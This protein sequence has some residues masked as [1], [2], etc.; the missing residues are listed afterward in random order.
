MEL[1]DAIRTRRSIRKF[2][3]DPVPRDIIIKI[4]EAA[5]LAPSAGNKQCWEF[6]VLQRS[7]LDRMQKILV[8]SFQGVLDA[9]S[10]DDFREIVKDLPIPCDDSQDK[11]DGLKLF[12]KYLGNAP[13]AIIVTVPKAEDKWTMHNNIKDG[14]AATQNLLL[15][16]WNEGLGTCWMT[17][18]LF[19]R[20]NEIF[21]F[22]NISKQKE[23]IGIIPLGVPDQHPSTPIKVDVQKITFWLG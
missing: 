8:D 18:P 14:S 17:G 10:E 21:R 6:L 12:F 4:L 20:E 1:I 13:L 23:I 3:P 2:K 5:N 9:V 22:L 16:A 11:V 19:M 7:L 15:A